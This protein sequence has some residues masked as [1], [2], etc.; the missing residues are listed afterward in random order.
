PPSWSLP[1]TAATSLSS[2]TR[3]PI[4]IASVSL[5]C[6]TATQ[7]PRASAGLTATPAAVTCRSP[8]GN[9]ALYAPSGCSDPALPSAA[10]TCF[11]SI[12]ASGR[13]LNAAW[14]ARPSRPEHAAT[15]SARAAP[16]QPPAIH[17]QVFH[18]ALWRIPL[19][20]DLSAGE[21]A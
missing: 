21:L 19:S 18:P 5:T 15:T 13:S 8:R 3:S 7:E 6:L 20:K 1:S 14:A 4:A 2:S 11:Q 10:S 16:L 9:P 12:G 17:Q